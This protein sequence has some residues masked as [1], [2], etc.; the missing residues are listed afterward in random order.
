MEKKFARYSLAVRCLSCLILSFALSYA[1]DQYFT[2][3]VPKY[4]ILLAIL[5]I[6]AIALVVDIF[7]KKAPVP[8]N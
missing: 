8:Q 1:V 3:Q 6:E 7:K 4:F 2:L 5:V